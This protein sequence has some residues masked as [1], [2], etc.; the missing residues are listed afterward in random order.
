ME[1]NIILKSVNPRDAKPAIFTIGG[2]GAISKDGKQYDFDWNEMRANCSFKDGFLIVDC[3]L[4]DF[5]DDSYL[6]ENLKN[7]VSQKEI[8]ADFITSSKLIEVFYECYNT[9]LDADNDL[10]Q[11]DLLEFN[12]YCDRRKDCEK[13]FPKEELD[14]YN[15]ESR[16][17]KVVR[18]ND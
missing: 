10:I 6:E 3:D 8:T 9:D 12:I 14:R 1:A 2:Y 15:Q 4:N 18:F 7:N 13:S 16:L 5:D 17:K 11:L